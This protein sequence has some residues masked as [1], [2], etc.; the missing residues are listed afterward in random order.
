M[1]SSIFIWHCNTIDEDADI[2]TL[3]IMAPLFKDVEEGEFAKD[4]IEVVWATSY[5]FLP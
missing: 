3:F 2:E 1:S 4:N 5:I